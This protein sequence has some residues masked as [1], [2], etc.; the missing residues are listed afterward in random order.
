M[1]GVL[2]KLLNMLNYS[3]SMSAK[4]DSEPDAAQDGKPMRAGPDLVWV[5]CEGYRCMAY[6]DVKGKW[7]SFPAR[8]VLTDFV[9]VIK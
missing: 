8:K 1:D 9:R 4:V 3:I 5:Q 2:P 7:V 6:L